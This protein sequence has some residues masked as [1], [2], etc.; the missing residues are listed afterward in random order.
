MANSMDQSPF[1]SHGMHSRS[2]CMRF[3]NRV[4]VYPYEKTTDIF[5]IFH[6]ILLCLIRYLASSIVLFGSAM[7]NFFKES[8][9]LHS[10]ILKK[11]TY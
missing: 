6:I 11:T 4:Y 8:S 9:P 7:L 10:R 2:L 5:S 3:F 1:D